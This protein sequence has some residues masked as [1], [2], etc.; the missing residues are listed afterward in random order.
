MLDA[1]HSAS[2]H[3]LS[4]RARVEGA[5]SPFSQA[6]SRLQTPLAHWLC[7]PL[8]HSSFLLLHLCRIDCEHGSRISPLV[9]ECCRVGGAG[10]CCFPG[11]RRRRYPSPRHLFCF[12]KDWNDPS[13]LECK[14]PMA[15]CLENTR[16]GTGVAG[17][18]Q[19]RTIITGVDVIQEF[20]HASFPCR[21]RFSI[22]FCPERV[23]FGES[24]FELDV[25]KSLADVC[26]SATPVTGVN[27]N[28]FAE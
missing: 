28:C 8:A 10:W 4:A 1:A 21:P 25:W 15:N 7:C 13:S 2:L 9:T 3:L 23:L 17:K 20:G 16:N 26:S 5:R 12:D 6:T 27:S 24:G 22:F 14:R 11:R 19:E 18:R